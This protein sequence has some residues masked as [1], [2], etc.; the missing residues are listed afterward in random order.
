MEIES[1]VWQIGFI[2]LIAGALIG[3]LAYRFFTAQSTNEV[4]RVRSELD[5]ARKE[6]DSY[7][8]GVTQHF[9]KTAELVNDLAQ[10]YVKVYQH[11]A[12][13]AET[14]GASRSFDD[15]LER[16]Q[17]RASIAS[18]DKN[19]SVVASATIDDEVKE[20][21]DVESVGEVEEV[22]EAAEAEEAKETEEATVVN[23]KTNE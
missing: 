13:G 8:S 23:K 5:D 1:S 2:A 14:L 12:E 6:L 19:D 16:H 11:L 21:A 9:D 7:K 22:K 10:N 20:T 18:D 17:D 3:A 15:L 4:D